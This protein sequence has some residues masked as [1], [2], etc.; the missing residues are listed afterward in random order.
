MDMMT[1]VFNIGD[2]VECVL[3]SPK[4]NESIAIGM[5]GV[6]CNIIKSSPYIGVRWNERLVRGHDCQGACTRGYG[7]FVNARDIKHIDDGDEFDA[8]T[9]EFDKLFESFSKETIS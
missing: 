4:G 9:T 2:K 3:D 6:V 7:W 1:E 8:D 5:Q